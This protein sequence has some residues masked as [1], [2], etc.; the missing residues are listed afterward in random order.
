[1]TRRPTSTR[2]VARLFEDI[3]FRNQV[4]AVVAAALGAFVLVASV[5]FG[6]A[7]VR[8]SSQV[9][10][11][12]SSASCASPD[13]SLTTTACRYRGS[14]TVVRV[15]RS[16]RLMTVVTFEVLPG[17][18]FNTSFPVDHEPDQGALVVGAS[19]PAEIW[20][21]RVT[22]MAGKRTFDNPEI[23]PT[24]SLLIASPALAALG[25]L[26]LSLSYLMWR[27]AQRQLN[28]PG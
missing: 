26:M 12:H 21:G 4:K 23:R 14:A 20:N 10:T 9:D 3:Q 16:D 24:V 8:N 19:A 1:M 15:Y 27:D 11:Y 5:L 18:V 6:I 7:Y 13:Q 25:F 28:A 22:S 17:H 2:V